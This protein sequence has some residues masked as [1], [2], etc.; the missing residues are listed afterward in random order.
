MKNNTTAPK[1][2]DKE[3]TKIQTLEIV[4]E[5]S[6]LA[7]MLYAE[8]QHS[9]LV[10]LQGMDGAGKDGVTKNVFSGISPA[11]VRFHAFKKPSEEEMEHDFLWRAR[12][13]PK[14]S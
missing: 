8:R 5:I 2:L 11:F 7:T 1:D 3:K 10:V 14:I 13:H 9:L 12:P 6:E 4:N